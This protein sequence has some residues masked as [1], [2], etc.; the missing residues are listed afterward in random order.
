VKLRPL[1]SAPTSTWSPPPPE[2]EAAR[3]PETMTH[4]VVSERD[5]EG[6]P[7]VL[8]LP[9]PLAG[10]QIPLFIR[11]PDGRRW[12]GAVESTGAIGRDTRDGT[13]ARPHELK[14][15]TPGSKI[16]AAVDPSGKIVSLMAQ[17]S[18]R[19]W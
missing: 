15:I 6:V 19:R 3:I 12:A 2:P 13:D 7:R 5:G 4:V 8:A 16:I 10:H 14:K 17:P 18:K 11:T 9:R 1:G